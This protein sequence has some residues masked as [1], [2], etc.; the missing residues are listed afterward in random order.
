LIDLSPDAPQGPIEQEQ[1][2]LREL[3]DY[4]ADLLERPRVIIGSRSDLAGEN[5]HDLLLVSSVTGD[6]LNTLVGKLA[7]LVTQARENEAEAAQSEI[8]V[9]RPLPEEIRIEKAGPNSW[10]VLGR[11]ALRAVRFQDLTND[12][13]LDEVVRRLKDLGVDRLLHRAGVHE[14]DE[15]TLGSLTFEWWRDQ[16]GA[17]LD[18]G[19]K[20][21]TTRRERLARHGR[22]DSENLVELDDDEF[23]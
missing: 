15:V 18:R 20:H 7:Q 6:G 2:L 16:G 3:G 10:R 14:G 21:R 22:L 11:P 17:G 1:I 23:S 19:E 9:H 4:Q 8:I 5:E 12:E 13:A